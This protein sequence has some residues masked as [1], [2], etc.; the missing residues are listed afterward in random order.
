MRSNRAVEPDL[1]GGLV[2]HRSV[3]TSG[4]DR[5][6]E[7]SGSGGL[8]ARAS[9]SVGLLDTVVSSTNPFKEKRVAHGGS[10]VLRVELETAITNV[11]GDGGS[12]GG[13]D[14]TSQNHEDNHS[15]RHD[16]LLLWFE[17]KIFFVRGKKK[18]K[19]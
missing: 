7:S 10:G 11:D 4:L 3:L 15:A 14:E 5:G 9:G 17:G 12:V 2:D 16:E 13:G 6:S 8:G 18:E 1:A 19:T